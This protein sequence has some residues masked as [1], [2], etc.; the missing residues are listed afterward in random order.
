MS[1]CSSNI[2]I[3][4]KVPLV[5]FMALFSTIQHSASIKFF[6]VLH[7]CHISHVD[8]KEFTVIEK[9]EGFASHQA[10]SKETSFYPSDKIFLQRAEI[11]VPSCSIVMVK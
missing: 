7:L 2:I 1:C 8:R 11:N 10:Y 3:V 5:G 6:S 9:K 4:I